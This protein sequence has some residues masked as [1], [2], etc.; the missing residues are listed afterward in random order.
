[1]DPL[2]PE[3]LPELASSPPPPQ[4]NRNAIMQ[5][6]VATDIKDRT[7]FLIFIS[8][9]PPP[10]FLLRNSDCGLRNK[11][12]IP[13]NLFRYFRASRPGETKATAVSRGRQRRKAAKVFSI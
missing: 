12:A 10:F 8:L 13:G 9:S 5:M 4:E 7:D 2:C 1:M 11:T 3:E 6:K